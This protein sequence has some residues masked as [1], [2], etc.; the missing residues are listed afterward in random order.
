MKKQNNPKPI[1]ILPTDIGQEMIEIVK[2]SGYIPLITDSPEKVKVVMPGSEAIGSDMLMSAMH[3]LSGQY[4]ETG[5]SAFV[6]ELAK[7]LKS[8]ESTIRGE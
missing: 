6:L 5:R 4:M 1:L 2:A 7:R 8:R 3:A